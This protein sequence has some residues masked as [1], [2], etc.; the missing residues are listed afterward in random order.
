MVALHLGSLG[1]TSPDFESDGPIPERHTSNGE[2]TSP[3]L[4]FTNVPSGAASLAVV[5]HDPDAPATH[6]FDHWVLYNLPPDTERVGRG[7]HRFAT[8]GSNSL[9]ALGYTGPAP[10]PGHGVH[11]YFFH[12]Y[13]L[14][15]ELA[16]D[17]GISRRVLLDLIDDHIVEQA[18]V[19]G[20]YENAR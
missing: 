17:G 9:G 5:C 19:V 1:I 15:T 11:H 16:A 3:E 4:V 14:D 7:G 18:R 10:P 20:T 2:N 12:L 13:A 6:G 8:E